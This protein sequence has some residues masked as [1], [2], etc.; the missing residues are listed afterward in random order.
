MVTSVLPVFASCKKCSG[1]SMGGTVAG[2]N[3]PARSRL[4]IIT[5]VIGLHM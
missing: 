5:R 1:S 2:I 4:N 3:Q